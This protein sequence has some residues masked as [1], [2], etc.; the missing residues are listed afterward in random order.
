MRKFS[1]AKPVLEITDQIQIIFIDLA[2]VIK[3]YF[4]GK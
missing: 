3:I 1:D 4:R 2:E